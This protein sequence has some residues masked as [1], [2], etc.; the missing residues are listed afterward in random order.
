[1]IGIILHP[2][3]KLVRVEKSK[4]RCRFFQRL[5]QLPVMRDDVQRIAIRIELYEKQLASEPV[6]MLQTASLVDMLSKMYCEVAESDNVRMVRNPAPGRSTRSTFFVFKQ[7]SAGHAGPRV[8][9][10]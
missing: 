8:P 10:R 4:E 2:N 6:S 1:M 5:I 7:W 3:K 9:R